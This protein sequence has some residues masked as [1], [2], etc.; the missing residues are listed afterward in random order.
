MTT[1][2]WS[3]ASVVGI[4]NSPN[5]PN[6]RWYL[7]LSIPHATDYYGRLV[8]RLCE[9]NFVHDVRIEV[10]YLR[11]NQ[12]G[13]VDRPPSYRR[14]LVTDGVRRQRFELAV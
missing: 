10:S 11:N 7:I 13:I 14:I 6:V 8:D 3:A 12:V 2:N 5:V 9:A 4:H 1:K